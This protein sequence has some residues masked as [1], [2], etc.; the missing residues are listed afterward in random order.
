MGRRLFLQNCGLMAAAVVTQQTGAGQQTVAT[1]PDLDPNVL[2][3]FVDALP[4]PEIARPD[5]RRP[6]PTNAGVQVPYYRLAMKPVAVKVHRDLKPT[7]MWGFG[8]G[9]PGPTF[10]TRSG[11]GLLV[12]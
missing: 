7:P 11:E 8:S 1:R 2:E 4:V 6:S 12:E 5:G 10:E 3:P 9:S